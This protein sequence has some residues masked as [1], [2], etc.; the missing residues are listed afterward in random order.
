MRKIKN[1]VVTLKGARQLNRLTLAQA[2]KKLNISITAL[3][4]Y[5]R[6]E[7]S[8]S[9]ALYKKISQTYG[10]PNRKIL[11][12]SEGDYEELLSNFKKELKNEKDY[13]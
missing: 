5:E 10:I 6:G 9:L 8:P 2:A 3:S 13:L 4:M 1:V 7:R 12:P 11:Y